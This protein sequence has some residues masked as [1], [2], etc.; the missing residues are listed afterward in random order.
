MVVINIDV[1]END[2]MRTKPTLWLLCLIVFLTILAAGAQAQPREVTGQVM[3]KA[4]DAKGLVGITLSG[5]KRYMAMT[6][7][8]GEFRVQNVE[9]GR[10]T[11][12]VT[13]GN[14]VQRF[15]VD[16]DGSKVLPLQVK[17]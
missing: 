16:I 10:Y 8:M 11:V 2:D 15:I 9:R 7:S 4:G 5:P 12:T 14:N 13:Q 6:N 17:W 1:K 3:G